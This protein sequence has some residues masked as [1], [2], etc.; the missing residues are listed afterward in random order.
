M[1]NFMHLTILSVL[2]FATTANAQ[3][4]IVEFQDS[5][6]GSLPLGL[7]AQDE[8]FFVLLTDMEAG[9]QSGTDLVFNDVSITTDGG[10]FTFDLTVTPGT[11]VGEISAVD[12]EFNS[13]LAEIDAGEMAGSLFEG[14]DTITI[15]VSDVQ[16]AAYDGFVNFGTD[17]SAVGEGFNI[18]GIDYIRGTETNGDAD[19]RQGIALPDPGVLALDSVDITF[20][21]DSV[22]LRGVALQFTQGDVTVAHGNVNLDPNGVVN[23]LD[24]SPFISVLA[25]GG[26][27]AEEAAA[28]CNNDGVASFLDIA[29]FITA[30]AGGGA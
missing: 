26:S 19:P 15:S 11:G 13:S 14:G 10:T 20:I 8:D 3:T 6:M 24:I 2:F 30:L 21:G 9:D 7:A 29:P 4:S 23:F 28:D 1:K 16:G 25:G 18:D 5:F 22:S 17:N 27:E 12:G